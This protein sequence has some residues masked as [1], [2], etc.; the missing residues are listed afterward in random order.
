MPKNHLKKVIES[1]DHVQAFEVYYGLGVNRS[2]HEVG[3]V[4]GKSYATIQAWSKVFDWDNRVMQLDLQNSG[5]SSAEIAK[6]IEDTQIEKYTPTTMEQELLLKQI[7]RIGVMLDK[8]FVEQDGKII[9][10][11]AIVDVDDFSKMVKAYKDLLD[12]Y[13]KIS[14]TKGGASA[15]EF[16]RKKLADN[17]NL[18]FNKVGD[19]KLPMEELIGF[20]T[21][22]DTGTGGRGQRSPKKRIEEADFSEVSGQRGQDGDGPGDVD[23][24]VE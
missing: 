3:R 13:H 22:N 6:L 19:G 11:I 8:V 1:D 18:I 17:V 5:G 7:E 9:P 16:E 15:K 24:V 2:L 21:G 20:L 4:V 23:T 10:N 12:V 14:M